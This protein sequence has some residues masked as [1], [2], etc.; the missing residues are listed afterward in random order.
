MT[1]IRFGLAVLTVCA[2]GAYFTWSRKP[3]DTDQHRHARQLI[4]NNTLSR[5]ND[6]V[7]VVGDSIVEAATLPRSICGHPIVNAGLI[8]SSTTSDLG[9]WLALA[10]DGKRAALIVV[11]L[12]INDVL[13]STPQSKESFADRYAMLLDQLSKLTPQLAAL[14]IPQVEAKGRITI[15]MRDEAIST[16]NGYN[17]ILPGLAARHGA[18][19]VSLSAMP[20]LHTMDG[21]HLNSDGYQAWEEAVMQAATKICG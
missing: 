7:I 11:S 5:V 12:G 19:F 13:I 20:K 4:L 14:E 8:G 17:S 18:T 9:A 15:A 21:V 16:I 10:L 3:D 1:R 6:P 2:V